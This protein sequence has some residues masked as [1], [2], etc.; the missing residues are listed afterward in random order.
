MG[1]VKLMYVNGMDIVMDDRF[2]DYSFNKIKLKGNLNSYNWI[3]N[4]NDLHPKHFFI[5][6]AYNSIS[7]EFLEINKKEILNVIDN[8]KSIILIDRIV[9]SA[10]LEEIC[11]FIKFI[12]ENGH[13]NKI[14]LLQNSFDNRD[15]HLSFCFELLNYSSI[16]KRNALS[17]D[18]QSWKSYLKLPNSM[19]RKF[20][21]LFYNGVMKS[22]RILL[23]KYILED[24]NNDCLYSFL[25]RGDYSVD[26]VINTMIEHNFDTTFVEEFFD[27]FVPS[28]INETNS[29]G[30]G[31]SDSLPNRD[32]YDN[33]YFSV[34]TESSFY[35]GNPR[36]TDKIF[37][38][39]IFHPF[40]LASSC[41]SLKLFKNFGFKTFPNIFD[42][43]YDEIEDDY[44][45]L[46]FVASEV[47]RV[48]N[49]NNFD[50]EKMFDD[51]RDIILHNQTLFKN[52]NYDEWFLKELERAIQ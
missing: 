35:D 50:M 41:G 31:M 26:R 6:F 37:K 2:S 28:T 19:N 43:S 36:L 33:T 10:Q 32:H 49:F 5:I 13:R 1:Y 34:I 9:E 8:K 30:L 39:C 7:D 27:R 51:S 38:A 20:K 16:F 46:K 45:R 11:E 23:G 17:A 24:N 12:R 47:E 18:N 40:I 15:Q 25:N 52:I 21:F 29:P 4:G 22:H 14:F 42:E 3:N 44:E 48:R